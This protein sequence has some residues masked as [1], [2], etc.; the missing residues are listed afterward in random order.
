MLGSHCLKSWSSTQQSITLSSGEAELVAAVKMC[1]EV[2][3]ISQLAR[4]WGVELEESTWIHR[5][6]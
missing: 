6:R 3:G 4:G 2:I 1:T 5:R